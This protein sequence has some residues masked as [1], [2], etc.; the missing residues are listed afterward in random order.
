MNNVI[1]AIVLGLIQGLTE[2]LPISS[3]A[4]LLLAEKVVSFENFPVKPFACIAQ[5]GSVIALLYVYGGSLLQPIKT[6]N[7]EK[8]S[9]TFLYCVALATVPAALIGVFCYS[10][11][12]SVLYDPSII[13]ASLMAGGVIFLYLGKRPPTITSFQT[14]DTKPWQ[15]SAIGMAQAIALIPGVSRSGSTIASGLAVG[16]GIKAATEFS[17]IL[18]I[19]TLCGATI[20]DIYKMLPT[21]TLNH[22]PILILG[23]FL[24][25]ISSFFVIR[26]FVRL[27]ERRGLTPFGW[28]RIA[29]G[30]FILIT[31]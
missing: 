20:Y 13:A 28:Y 19:P 16:M 12:K 31:L 15:A 29:L 26:P 18:A 10:Y 11:I 22:L 17:F 2:F 23:F 30:L 9:R 24:S 7:S 21:L 14:L 25:C 3:T 5:L 4:H 27:I 1:A 8:K 6:W